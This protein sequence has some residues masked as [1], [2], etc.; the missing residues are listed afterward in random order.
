MALLADARLA[1]ALL[2]VPFAVRDRWD[3]L[4]D[5]F[6][7]ELEPPNGS[8]PFAAGQF[9]MLYAFGIGE[10]PI[11]ISGD[12][13]SAETLVHTIRGVG[14]VTKALRAAQPGSA[15]GVRGPFGTP[16][17]LSDAEGRDVVF[18]AGG[19]GLAPLRSAVYAVLHDR[20]R[21]GRVVLLY[22]ARSPRE[23]LYADLIQEWRGRFDMDVLV[24]VDNA[25]PGWKGSVGVVTNLIRRAPF[26]PR[27]A[28]A[29]VCGP[30]IMMRFTADNLVDRGMA[31]SQIHLSME[32]N[33]KCAVG[34]CGHCQLNRFFVC[35]D[36]PIFAYS[37][38]VAL[39]KVR[40]V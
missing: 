6:T 24:T 40:E 19:I 10:V 25:G 13:S 18:V 12:P 30:E 15:V 2:P 39:M 36:G 31:E 5:T 17:P 1:D 11:S 26:D 21:Y 32:R 8:Y 3:E 7:I 29:F 35:K 27:E 16:W 14:A 22:G 20:D 34:F 9:T 23:L 28:T 33:M 4:E 37:D 38:V